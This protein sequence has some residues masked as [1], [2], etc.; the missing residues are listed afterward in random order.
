MPPP[1]QIDQLEHEGKGKAKLMAQV[2]AYR[3]EAKSWKA[4]AVSSGFPFCR[5]CVTLRIA[6]NPLRLLTG[7]MWFQTA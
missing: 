2:R 7:R 1:P 6:R 4:K 5:T 3:Q